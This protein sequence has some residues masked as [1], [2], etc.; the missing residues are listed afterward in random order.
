MKDYEKGQK[1]YNR[2]LDKEVKPEKSILPFAIFL[3]VLF[4]IS[5]LFFNNYF[6]A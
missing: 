2:Y 1:N 3:V 6:F 4:L 5:Y